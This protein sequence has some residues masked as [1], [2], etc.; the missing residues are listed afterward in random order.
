MRKFSKQY[1]ENCR[2][3]N[4]KLSSCFARV[5]SQKL[6]ST[7]MGNVSINSVGKESVNQTG[8]AGRTK[9]LT[10]VSQEGLTQEILAR[11]SY[12]HLA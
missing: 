9:C 7:F 5:F 2:Y 10:S 3:D 6:S 12:L 4:L 11:H 1:V 8:Q